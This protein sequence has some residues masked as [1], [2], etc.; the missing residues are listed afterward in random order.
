MRK[1]KTRSFDKPLAVAGDE[2]NTVYGDLVTFIMM[3][4]ILLFILSYN[5]KE[6]EDFFT[7]MNVKFG[8][9]QQA[10]QQSMTTDY[11]LVS[12][13]QN[14]IQ[15]EKLDQEIQV[16]VD[17]QKIKL[18]MAPS[19]LFDSGEAS[20]KLKGYDALKGVSDIL[21]GVD[22]PVI[23]EGHTDNIP[24]HTID[25]DSNWELSFHR[26]L[27]VLKYF[28]T[29]GHSPQNFSAQGFGEYRP[30]SANNTLLGRQKNR[31]IEINIIRVT[32]VQKH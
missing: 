17:E 26:A 16:L 5:Q 24:I 8:G 9:E 31:R 14:F 6:N 20:V 19:L 27:S 3:L 1:K 22:N 30:V 28:F 2:I 32:K 7:Q 4:F 21:K 11:Q 15:K 13:L 23:I 18:I 12:Q 29:E 10:S 25:F